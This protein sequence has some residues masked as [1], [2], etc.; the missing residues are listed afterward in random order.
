MGSLYQPKVSF[1]EGLEPPKTIIG[2]WRLKRDSGPSEVCSEFGPYAE[3]VPRMRS[4]S[5]RLFEQLEIL[6]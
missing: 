1:E 3:K 5:L 2:F 6:R 4:G